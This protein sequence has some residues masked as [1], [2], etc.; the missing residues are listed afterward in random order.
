MVTDND[1]KFVNDKW[2]VLNSDDFHHTYKCNRRQ[3]CFQ[4]TRSPKSVNMLFEGGK[5]KKVVRKSPYLHL[6]KK[7]NSTTLH[8][9]I[10]HFSFFKVSEKA[11]IAT[12]DSVKII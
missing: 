12:S 9:I 7:K 10:K 6:P 5:R 2:H 3:T 11:I 8:L 4:I 1:R